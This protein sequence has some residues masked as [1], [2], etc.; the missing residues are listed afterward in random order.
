MQIL[1]IF[2]EWKQYIEINDHL[3]VHSLLYAFIQRG[4]TSSCMLTTVVAQNSYLCKY[5]AIVDF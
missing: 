3:L 4:K 1:S 5:Q 2:M